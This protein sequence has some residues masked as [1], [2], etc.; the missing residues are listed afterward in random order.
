M[1]MMMTEAD[2]AM[3]GSFVSEPGLD[4]SLE[5]RDKGSDPP[6][7][8]IAFILDR[9]HETHRR[10]LPELIRL[11]ERVETVHAAHPECPTGLAGFLKVTFAEL[12]A[13]MMKEEQMLF[14]ALLAGGAGCAPFAIRRMRFEH[15]EHDARLVE[16]QAGA[17]AFKPPED[18]C[19]SWRDLYAGCRKLHDDLRAHIDTENNVLFPMFE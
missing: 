5:R 19:K 7:A 3:E 18:A 11:A 1:M 15:A 12:E 14:P 2:T 13:H 17:R 4:I 10:E 6:D 16:L 8:L 9:F